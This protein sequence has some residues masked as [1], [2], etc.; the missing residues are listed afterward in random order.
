[1]S[2]ATTTADCID[3][4]LRDAAEKLLRP[5][6]RKG[7]SVPTYPFTAH[8]T[9][10]DLARIPDT[11]Q[12]QPNP[13]GEEYFNA[14]RVLVADAGRTYGIDVERA[15]A[16]ARSYS[17]NG[18][19]P[20]YLPILG[21]VYEIQCDYVWPAR[22]CEEELVYLRGDTRFPVGVVRHDVFFCF[23]DLPSLARNRPVP[24][25]VSGA[26]QKG[27]EIA[28]WRRLLVAEILEAGFNRLRTTWR[29]G[30]TLRAQAYYR[31]R[32]QV[33][34]TQR[35]E[36]V[37]LRDTLLVEIR[38]KYQML[39]ELDT[40]L[41]VAGATHSALDRQIRFPSKFR[42]DLRREYAALE[43]IAQTSLE[44]LSV[45]REA[46]HVTTLPIVIEWEG[47]EYDFGRFEFTINARRA[48]EDINFRALEP[49]TMDGYPHPHIDT[50]GIPCLGNIGRDLRE[51][52]KARDF[53]GVIT[54]LLAFLHSY[55]EANPYV[56]ITRWNEDYDE[57]EYESC[58]NNRSL[59]DCATCDDSDCPY[60][61][62]AQEACFENT[63][64]RD[65]A[66]C[67]SCGYG[68]EAANY[69]SAANYRDCGSACRDRAC[70]FYGDFEP[71]IEHASSEQCLACDENMC[72]RWE[73][74]RENLEEEAADAA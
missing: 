72:S 53:A 20:L 26:P 31:L 61:D 6:W 16:A 56:E 47:T 29:R 38:E 58:H 34:L 33:V 49:Q 30:R 27:H 1:M 71:C 42:K 36:Q 69:C 8:F 5:I 44:S 39:E 23:I 40:Q 43:R 45:H 55:N 7:H 25:Q 70:V 14:V 10:T 68:A 28:N 52:L 66:G 35:Q 48:S 3:P 17:N 41:Q 60:R 12:E 57:D 65:C 24:R 54:L 19:P 15:Y 11:L 67:N 63:D 4:I 2:L 32:E 62:G 51:A 74:E 22:V 64:A 73:D 50:N 21:G 37:Y 13:G 18:V 46:L 59:F 9:R